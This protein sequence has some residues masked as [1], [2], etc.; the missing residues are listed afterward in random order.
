MTIKG[1]IFDVGNVIQPVDWN[2]AADILNV[3]PEKYKEA[4]MKDREDHFNLYEKGEIHSLPYAAFVL[5]NLGINAS[6]EN[7]ETFSESSKYLWGAP[8]LELVK[9]IKSL[10]PELR[11]AILTNSYPEL[12]DRAKSF[13]GT[14][15]GYLNLFQNQVYWSHHIE[16]KKP[17]RKAYET[18]TKG[19]GLVNEEC[20]FIDDKEENV[21]AARKF[22]L[23]AIQY[24]NSKDLEEKLTLFF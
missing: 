10:N 9:H 7:I 5:G 3:S 23:E 24:L 18:A 14:E 17:E 21:L 11:K 13:N 4:F 20:L 2:T 19:L 12:E 8:N 22:G 6:K 1:I 16:A 15:L